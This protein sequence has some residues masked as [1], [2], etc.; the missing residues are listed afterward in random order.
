VQRTQPLR[1]TTNS[2]PSVLHG[3]TAA[4]L[5]TPSLRPLT[6]ETSVGFE[7][8]E[9]AARVLNRPL[10]P[11]QDYFV[12]AAGELLP[13]GRPRFRIV[14]GIV[15][16]QN[17]KTEIPVVLAPYWLLVDE[18]RLVL[19]TSTKLEYAKDTWDKTRLLLKDSPLV[20]LMGSPRWYVRGNN[21]T[22]MWT[23]D[24]RGHYRIAAANEEGGRS[25]TIDRAVA[26][27]LRQHH[28]YSAWNAMEP[29]A[30]HEWSQIM[31]LSNAGDDKSIVLNDLRAA[32][33]DYIGWAE[34]VGAENAADLIAAG[35]CPY[36]YRLGLFEWSAPEDADPEDVGALLQA[37][38]RVG[39]GRN[40]EDLLLE[41]R[42]AK[43]K[44]GE[45]LTGFKTEKMCIRVPRLSPAIDLNAW[46]AAKQPGTLGNVRNRVV[47]CVDVSLDG[48]HATAVAAATLPD[49]KIRV[50]AVAAWDSAFAMQV[51]LPDLVEKIKPRA[52]GWFPN[53]PAAAVAAALADRNKVGEARR[54]WPPRSVTVEAISQEMPAVCMGLAK[55]VS[56]GQILHSGDP[57]LDEQV[58]A[59]EKH[60]RI[61]GTWVFARGDEGHVDAVYAMAGAVH[62]ARTLPAPVGGLRLIGPST[63]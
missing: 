52:V 62:L 38:P 60:E 20:S 55:D 10:L 41:A 40:L 48:A 53:G 6:P 39:Y 37:N 24:E 28:D 1:H 22:D 7:Q 19:G 51:G 15:A 46:R 43:A 45:A 35:Q 56:A 50:E 29:A 21:L 59:A 18:F 12:Q 54:P 25:L 42:R 57:L 27:E 44:G 58:Q 9:Y 23:A 13:D 31:A 34:Q 8:S 61:T 14:L 3:S 16:R 26:D 36:D 47:L 63:A 49:G 17:G 5:W 30:S 33:L 2:A 32:A 4:R 11:W